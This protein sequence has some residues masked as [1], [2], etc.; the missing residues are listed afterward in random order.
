MPNYRFK[1]ADEQKGEELSKLVDALLA[2]D[3]SLP[4]IRAIQD[5]LFHTHLCSMVEIIL[6]STEIQRIH[7][8]DPAIV[9]QIKD[10]FDE[11]R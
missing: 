4:Q 9:Q 11:C 6:N 10:K 8:Y 3:E 2:P 1:N 5:F 7:P